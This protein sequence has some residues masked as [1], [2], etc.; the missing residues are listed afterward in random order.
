[1]VFWNASNVPSINTCKLLLLLAVIG[2]TEPPPS[3]LGQDV[4]IAGS[5]ALQ[6]KRLELPDDIT[7]T[8]LRMQA[9][10]AATPTFR[11]QK[12]FFRTPSDHLRHPWI[13]SDADISRNHFSVTKVYKNT[14]DQR[15]ATRYKVNF[16]R[17][18]Q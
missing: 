1:M 12:I 4:F 8:H 7:M 11:W 6:L 10:V 5:Q 18:T 16:Q 15:N 2:I 17:N 14:D 3:Y 13:L 9:V